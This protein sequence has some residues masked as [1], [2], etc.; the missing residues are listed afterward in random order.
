MPQRLSGLTEAEILYVDGT[1]AGKLGRISDRGFELTLDSGT[2]MLRF[3]AVDRV[4]DGR[5]VLACDY[6]SLAMYSLPA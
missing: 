5:V 6:G 1:R 4:E 3:E 2:V